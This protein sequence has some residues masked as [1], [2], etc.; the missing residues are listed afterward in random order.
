MYT[1]NQQW[2]E[3]ET[4]RWRKIFKFWEGRTYSATNKDLSLKCDHVVWLKN[5]KKEIDKFEWVIET[6]KKRGRPI[7]Y[8][9]KPK[10]VAVQ[11]E[12]P[13]EEPKPTCT[14]ETL[15]TEKYVAMIKEYQTRAKMREDMYHW[16]IQLDANVRELY[17][18]TVATLEHDLNIQELK[19]N[20]LSELF[21]K[22]IRYGTIIILIQLLSIVFILF[23]S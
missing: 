17:S 9:P 10:V 20:T 21:N 6:K 16:A 5:I 3:V 4:Y 23:C 18:S 13:K 7:G 11:T 14:A 2:L 12:K 15:D 8:I 19:Y 1:T 22:V